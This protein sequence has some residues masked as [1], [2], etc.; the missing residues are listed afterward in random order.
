MCA[1]ARL[2]A[3]KPWRLHPQAHE[4]TSRGEG[5]WGRRWQHPHTSQDPHAPHQRGRHVREGSG[6]VIIYT[7]AKAR[8]R[9]N[10][11]GARSR[12]YSRRLVQCLRLRVKGVGWGE[13]EVGFHRACVCTCVRECAR[14]RGG[15]S[16]CRRAELVCT[17]QPPRAPTPKQALGTHAYARVPCG[18]WSLS[19]RRFPAQC[20]RL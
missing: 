2:I 20:L 3:C 10:R 5:S 6:R 19:C 16:Q 7:R 8:L 18:A 4:G 13:G 1:P 11:G 9:A 15:T 17:P 12:S 14:V